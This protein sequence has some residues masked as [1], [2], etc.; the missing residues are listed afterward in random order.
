MYESREKMRVKVCEGRRSNEKNLSFVSKEH[1][2]YIK[3]FNINL[4][5]L[6]IEKEGKCEI[7]NNVLT[8]I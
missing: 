4:G 1:K 8:F 5:E 3:E 6:E 7:V 2:K